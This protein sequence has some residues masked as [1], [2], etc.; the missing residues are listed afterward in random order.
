MPT[1]TLTG[2]LNFSLIKW[3]SES[4]YGGISDMRTQPEAF[5]QLVEEFCL[6]QSIDISTRGDNIFDVV[7]TKN[8]QLLYDYTVNKT[9][10]SDH[11]IITVTVTI[12]RT[13]SPSL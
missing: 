5:L 1:V 6:I 8:E 12:V 4:V 10:L 7:M 2:D 13:V 3:K 9:N 11:N